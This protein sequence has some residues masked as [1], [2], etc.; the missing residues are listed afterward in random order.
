MALTPSLTLTITITLTITPT[1]TPTPT[2]NPTPKQEI[3][4][5]VLDYYVHHREQLR[6]G[7]AGYSEAQGK[8]F[9]CWR[10][11]NEHMR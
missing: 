8:G 4:H 5:N 2:P 1:P 6:R 9:I 7:V 3:A 11:V 10:F